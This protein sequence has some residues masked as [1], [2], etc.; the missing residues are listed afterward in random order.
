MA[1]NIEKLR[2]FAKLATVIRDDHRTNFDNLSKIVRETY[3]TRQTNR[4]LQW[5]PCFAEKL[6]K[7]DL[8]QE[9]YNVYYN[10]QQR[11]MKRYSSSSREQVEYDGIFKDKRDGTKVKKVLI[12]GD[13][14]IGKTTLCTSISVDWAKYKTLKQFE[15]LLLLPLRDQAVS[16]VHSVF[17]LLKLFHPNEQL[18]QSVAES[19]LHGELG[20]NVLLIA[21]GW[22]ELDSSYRK[23]GSFICKLL[24]SNAIHSATVMITSRPSASILLHKNPYIDRF[25]EIAGFDQ[26]GIEQYIESEFS[27]ESDKA[28][29][30]G[31]L[32]Q[33]KDNP[34]IRSICHVPI[35][36]AIVCHMW[37][38]DES[39]PSNMTLT[40]IYTKIILHFILRAFQKT[41]P[42]YGLESLNSFDAIPEDMQE[43]LWLLCKFAYDALEKNTYVFSYEELKEFFPQAAMKQQSGEQFTFGLMQSAQAFLGVGRGAS[44]HFLH[45]TFQEYMSAMHIVKQESQTQTDLMKPHAY[46]SRMAMV[47]RFVIG[48]GSSDRRISSSICP[49]SCDTVCEVYEINN[50]VRVSC[51][52]W[53]NDL[54]V[55]G[56]YEAKEGHVKNYLLNLLY[57]DYF[58]FAFP[59]NAHDCATVV[60]AID[61][62]P[63]SSVYSNKGIA[64]VSLKLEHCSLDEQLLTDLAVAL[65]STEGQLQIKLLLIQDNK[66]SDKA[67]CSLMRLAAP[68]LKSLKQLSFAA[69]C[70][71]AKAIS[72]I[73]EALG[74]SSMEHLTLSYN[75][76]GTSGVMALVNAIKEDTLA[77]LTDLQLKNCSLKNSEACASLL[78]VLP[79]HCIHLKQIDMSD[80]LVDNP[81]LLGEA[82]GNLILGHK[83]VFDIFANE[84]GL[85]DSGFQALI[86]VLSR[87]SALHIGTLSVKKNDI[88]SESI[89]LLAECIQSIDL[90]ISDGL[91]VDNNPIELKGAVSL[92]TVL[93]SKTV[94]MSNCKITTS[95]EDTKELLLHQLSEVPESK[96]C[97]E[98]ILD[99]N[100]LTK[101]HI[102][103]LAKFIRICPLLQSLS[104]AGCEINS[105]DLMHILRNPA[106]PLMALQT[107][108]LQT[109][110]VDDEGCTAMVTAVK[111]LPKL[112]GIFLHGNP[113]IKNKRLFDLLEKEVAK[114]RVSYL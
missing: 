30:D 106:C 33:I 114:H 69:N 20:K 24:F 82:M 1:T 98:L 21:D 54:V 56:I 22:D 73:S 86:N 27:M 85:G 59:R 41:F 47:M 6:V 8:H 101:E 76:L 107:L 92:C 55:H 105:D 51:V 80:N 70:L 18:C 48:L 109:N 46:T 95:T 14:G 9:T 19:F 87:G 49:L 96:F 11:G 64:T 10:K 57:G 32:Q 94:S 29:R 5:P 112:T 100:S 58:T 113:D 2:D 103:I 67:I 39:L 53:T 26:K 111:K 36:C 25:I 79:N 65:Y 50:R 89:S 44:F 23:P 74:K 40:D 15:L 34:L 61:N 104:C 102:D 68:A 75:P 66:L 110:K 16:T 60:N 37:R 4:D 35:N 3:C 17:E 91:Y 81:I 83:N 28:S 88:H 108:S 72:A 84:V 99:N 42:E 93:H 38:S 31:L 45:R 7:L 71:G 97:E 77:N 63:K 78:Q 52:G 43:R 12:E 62:F 90:Y 13:A